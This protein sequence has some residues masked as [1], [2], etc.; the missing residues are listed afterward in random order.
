MSKQAA[1]LPEM[2]KI[3]PLVFGFAISQI[4]G[5]T[6]RLGVP[7]LL[8]ESWQASVHDAWY[9]HP[10]VWQAFGALEDAVH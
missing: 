9:S 1:E 10:A 4:A 2:G 3:L 8:S 7:K 5:T 6:S